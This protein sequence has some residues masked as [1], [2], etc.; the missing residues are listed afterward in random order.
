MTDF[1]QH[2]GI[3]LVKAT[4]PFTGTDEDEVLVEVFTAVIPFRCLHIATPVVN[5]CAYCL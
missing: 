3:H 2:S 1:Q 5:L 4:F